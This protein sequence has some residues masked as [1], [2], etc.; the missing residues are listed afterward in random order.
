MSAGKVPPTASAPT[1]NYPMPADNSTFL[2]SERAFTV[3]YEAAFSPVEN[4]D[5]GGA[6]QLIIRPNRG[7]L[8]FT[9]QSR[10]IFSWKQKTLDFTAA[11]IWNVVQEGEKLSFSTGIGQSGR[12]NKRFEFL[13]LTA[14]EAAAVRALLPTRVDADLTEEQDFTVRLSLLPGSSS[15]LTS[16]TGLIIAANIVVFAVMATFLNAG[17]LEVSSMDPYI[18]FG[19]NSGAATTNGE[20][21]RLFTSV[22][23][24]FGLLH[25][26]LNMWSLLSVGSLLERLLSR[27]LYLF[28]YLA[29]G[30]GG[31]LTSIG[32][33]GDETWSAGASGAVF[34]IYGG[35]LGY[36]LREKKT[37]PRA[38]WTPL[39][40]SA[41]TFA[42]YNLF[43][44]LVHPGIDNAAHVGGLLTGLALG[45][46][47]AV[48]TDLERRPALIRKHLRLGLAV[49]VAGIAVGVAVVPRFDYLVHEEIAWAEWAKDYA[50]KETELI[51]HDEEER[52][53]AGSDAASAAKYVQWLGTN[54]IPFW[55]SWASQLAGLHYTPGR[56]T[57]H[58][59][60]VVLE[61]FRTQS[62]SYQHLRAGVDRD[63]AEEVKLYNE[64][65]EKAGLL[66][67]SLQP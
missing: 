24:H 10:R 45:W 11:D 40:K 34:G 17:W 32:W 66:L 46:L 15:L 38:V 26:A 49:A 52:K 31:S 28:L 53:L 43:Y 19:A 21:W 54:V 64:L 30:I 60:A 6:G 5:L 47:I 42:G 63:D 41:L 13:C 3:K 27:S 23:M 36:G 9:G 2:N 12:K 22:F 51:K 18:R 14:D 59:R 61:Y 16:V 62:E 48:P 58:R 1:A 57:E 20:W 44:G 55:D 50:E 37:L 29:S 39:Q 65:R 7:S 56:R 35:L 4:F 33:H 67:R 25:L 8:Q